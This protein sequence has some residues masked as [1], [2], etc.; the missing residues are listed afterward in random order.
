MLGAV[1][2]SAS[3]EIIVPLAFPEGVR[4]GNENLVKLT[5]AAT[6]PALISVAMS[7]RSRPFAVIIASKS[8]PSAASHPRD[9]S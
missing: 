9:V 1:S 6:A 5:P 4:E 7:T 3:P 2:S 8:R